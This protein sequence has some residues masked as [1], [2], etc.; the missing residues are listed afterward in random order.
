MKISTFDLN[1]FVILNAIYTE[2]SL[3]KAAEVVGIT[4]PAVSNAL[5][6]LREKFNDDLFV[7]TGS[8]MVPTQKTENIINDIQSALALMQQS[9]NEPDTFDAENTTRTFKLSLGDIS[10]GRVLPYIMKEIDQNAKN[11]SV[12]SYAYKR[13]DQVHALATHNLDFVVDPVIPASDEINSYK[14]FEDDFV[15]IH[16]EDHPL[17]KIEN[18]TIDDILSQGHLHVSSRKRGLHLIDVELDKIGYRRNVALRCQ[19]FLI[20]PTIVKST[21][22]VLFATRSFAKAHNLP[23]VEIP[24]KIPSMEYFL[25]W[26]KSD[27]GDGGHIWMKDLI[28]KAFIAAKK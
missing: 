23:F 12:G 8:G 27:E 17:S 5:S 26:H 9:V 4:Q 14:V 22:L 24:A 15:V 10:E 18:P 28:I 20:A 6:R 21:D 25:I 11:I 7:R 2:G 13:S 1:L 3:T 16:R 19:H